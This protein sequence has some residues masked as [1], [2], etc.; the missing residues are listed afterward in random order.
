MALLDEINERL[1]QAMR[2]KDERTLSVLR[3]VKSELKNYAIAKGLKDPLEDAHVQEVL[4]SYVRKLKN[5]IQEFE[6]GA[7]EQSKDAIERIRFEIGVLEPWMP[8]MLD[9]AETRKIVEAAVEELGRPPI[10]KAGMVIGKV[11][12]AHKGEVDPVMVRRLVE[13]ILGG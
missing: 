9:E 2:E 1:K 10:Q 7:S 4:T 5:A 11:M 6:K 3:M 12:K 13:E 8:K